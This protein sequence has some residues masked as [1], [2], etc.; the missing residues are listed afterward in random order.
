MQIKNKRLRKKCV[1]TNSKGMRRRN[2]KM[3]IEKSPLLAR[4]IFLSPSKPT[5]K[6][7]PPS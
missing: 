2:K 5:P 4:L 7:P 3:E 6:P 1:R